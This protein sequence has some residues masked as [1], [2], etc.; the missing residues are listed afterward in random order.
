MITIVSGS[1][2][3]TSLMMQMLVAGGGSP[4]SDGERRPTPTTPADYVAAIT[5][6]AQPP[7]PFQKW[8]KRQSRQVISTAC[9]P[10]PDTRSASSCSV[11]CP[12]CHDAPA[13]DLQGGVNSAHSRTAVFEKHLREVYAWLA[14]SYVQSLLVPHDVLQKFR[15][16][17]SEADTFS[18]N[19]TRC[20]S[21]GNNSCTHHRNRAI[22]ERHARYAKKV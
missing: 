11:R 20:G 3:R 14:G 16:D 6:A 8:R 5:A 22:S 12:G 9:S 1:P 19:F 7:G 10:Q 21:D 17:L 4:L 15:G 2:V 13:W 18:W